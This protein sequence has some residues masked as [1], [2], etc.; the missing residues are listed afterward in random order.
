MK[1]A[2]EALMD[3]YKDN[4]NIY[5][6]DVDCTSEAS[7]PLCSEVG[8]E[9]F[10]SLKYGDPSDLQDYSGGRS[11]K[12][13]KDFASTLKPLCSAAF[14]ELCDE[15]KKALIREY[16]ALGAEKREEMIKEKSA[17][18]EAIKQEFGT[19]VDDLNKKYQDAAAE[20]T[21]GV[22]S[23]KSDEYKLLKAVDIFEKR[24]AKSD[25]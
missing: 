11:L 9:G 12:E 22:E 16:I 21:A 13:L 2:W 25:L 24:A 23:V 5:I 7:K 6:F 15:E 3:E 4:K 17:K 19:F 14:L 10:P 8:V 20:K 18:A 1:P